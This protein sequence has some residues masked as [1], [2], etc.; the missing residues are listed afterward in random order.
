MHVLI[1]DD[2]A[3]MRRMIG[4]TLQLSGVPVDSQREAGHGAEALARLAEQPADLVLLDVNMPVMDGEETL[5]RLR[6]EPATA[7]VAVIVVSTEGSTTRVAALQALGAAFVHKPFTP[8][9]LRDVIHQVTGTPD[10][11]PD[12]RA[13]ALLGGDLDF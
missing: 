3:V 13:G 5:R 12:D 10:G 7:H 11:I 9:Q 6:A 1:V 2:S 8:E 4:R